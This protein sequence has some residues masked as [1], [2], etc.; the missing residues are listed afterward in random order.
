MVKPK[1]DKPLTPE[2]IKALFTE[3]TGDYAAR[4][5]IEQGVAKEVEPPERDNGRER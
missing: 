4:K 5:Q 3:M 2:Q 1:D